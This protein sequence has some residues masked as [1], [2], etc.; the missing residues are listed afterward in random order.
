[1]YLLLHS[2]ADSVPFLEIAADRLSHLIDT[3]YRNKS[4]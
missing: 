4:H 1:M 2:S 3:A